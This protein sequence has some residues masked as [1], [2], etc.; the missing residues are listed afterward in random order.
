MSVISFTSAANLGLSELRGKH[1]HYSKFWN[2]GSKTSAA[3]KIKLSSRTGMLI[4]YN[5]AFLASVT[6][7]YFI[8]KRISE[9]YCFVQP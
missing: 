7:F 6:S 8:L 1:L 2:S 3:K 4:A 9:S 5:P